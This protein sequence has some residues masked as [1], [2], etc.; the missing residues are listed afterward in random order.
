MSNLPKISII[1]P[2]FNSAAF[3]E[4]T[5][6]SVLSQ[7]YPALEY[8][9]IDGGSRDGT[10]EIIKKYQKHLFYSISEPDKGQSHAINKGIVRSTGEIV[11]WLNADDFYEKN[12]LF[13][14][15]KYFE[16]HSITCLCGRSNIVDQKGVLI[17][18]SSGTDVYGK[19]LAKTLGWARVNQPETFFRRAVFERLEG[20]NEKLHF[21]MDKEFWMRYLLAFGLK[22]VLLSDDVL[23]NFRLHDHSK[24][25]SNPLKFEEETDKI[26]C[27]LAIA[28]ERPVEANFIKEIRNRKDND[29]PKI[30]WPPFGKDIIDKLLSYHFLYLADYYY[31]TGEGRKSIELLN[32]V[33]EM[34]LE[35]ADITLFK[36]LKFKNK[37]VPGFVKKLK[38]NLL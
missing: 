26:F 16:D 23:V 35:A 22:G 32:A 17:G 37:F 8:I 27:S 30:N 15:A 19:N 33:Q 24:T 7:K 29:L 10:A 12:S 31:F 9:I 25:G 18:P 5:I 28:A 4:Q 11:N 36:R 6:D 38:H 14:I 20:V 13:K 1:T 34:N 3:I 21:V 2:S